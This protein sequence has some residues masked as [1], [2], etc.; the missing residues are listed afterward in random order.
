MKKIACIG[1]SLTQGDDFEKNNTWPA[2]LENQL[3][4]PVANLGVCGDTTSG[5]LSRIYPLVMETEPDILVII[6]GT[7]DLW[8]DIGIN[9]VLGNLFAM[10][11]QARYMD[12]SPVI[13]LP[14]P[15]HLE[16][17]QARPG[18]PVPF[19]GYAVFIRKLEELI[20]ELTKAAKEHDV[21]LADLFTPFLTE[22]GNPD[23]GT[24]SPELFLEDGI[25][26]NKKGHKV[27]AN[28]VYSALKTAFFL[29]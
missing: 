12:I 15:L 20:A 3:G 18:T 16:T 7:N 17:L 10:V 13:G 1:D 21:P 23:P 6:G 28:T 27:M 5:M 4:I 25:H 9:Q 24:G 19:G 22:S 11:S 2:L 29:P 8:W 26:P 14:L